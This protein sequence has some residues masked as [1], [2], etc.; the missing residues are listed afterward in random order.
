MR[1]FIFCIFI[2]AGLFLF[3]CRHKNTST[4]APL[5]QTNLSVKKPLRVGMVTGIKPE[6][7]AYYKKL[8]AN[9]WEGVLKNIEKWNIRNYSIYLKKI[10]DKY[11]L[12]SYYE[13]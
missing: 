8:H 4:N 5:N 12:F 6:K 3:S 2:L 1:Q 7:I 10:D 11:F 13:Y 9:T